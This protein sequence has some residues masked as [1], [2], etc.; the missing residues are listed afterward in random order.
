M[1]N[2]PSSG[3]LM[4]PVHEKTFFLSACV[5]SKTSGLYV[6]MMLCLMTHTSRLESGSGSGLG[7]AIGFSSCKL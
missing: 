4:F 2:Q 5:Y 7:A 3:N 1:I 6:H